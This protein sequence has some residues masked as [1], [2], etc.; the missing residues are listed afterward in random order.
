MGVLALAAI[1]GFGGIFFGPSVVSVA[2]VIL[3]VVRYEP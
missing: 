2:L 3:V 1:R